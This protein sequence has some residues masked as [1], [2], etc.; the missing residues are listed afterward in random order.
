MKSAHNLDVQRL[1]S[2]TSR[3]NEVNAGMDAVVNDVHA[4]DLV[5]SIQ[6]GIESLLN[7]VH[8]WSPRLVIVDKVSK[9]GCIN[10]G[11]T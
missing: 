9:S 6:V 7:V 8:D 2:M 1:Q 11:Q 4:V 10:N 3:L 5:L